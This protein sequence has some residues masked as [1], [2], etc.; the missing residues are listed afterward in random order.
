[1]IEESLR[2]ENFI[3]EEL[4]KRAFAGRITCPEARRLA[5]ELK[6][7]YRKVGDVIN[8]LGIKITNCDLGC[9]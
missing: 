2:R 7:S 5:E 4:K 6:V 1:M 9:F 8:K 3:E